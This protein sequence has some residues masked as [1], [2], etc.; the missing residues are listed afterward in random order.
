MR[1]MAIATA[2]ACHDERMADGTHRYSAEDIRSLRR[3]VE[4]LEGLHAA[5]QRWPEVSA[6]AFASD[7]P[8]TLQAQVSD[9]LGIGFEPATAV[10]DMQARRVTHQQ[11][12]RLE[13]ELETVREQLIAAL[14]QSEL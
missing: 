9:L 6:L 4:I 8:E 12:E 5:L 2:R 7:S 11:R 1:E 3:R 13:H 10:L 14:A